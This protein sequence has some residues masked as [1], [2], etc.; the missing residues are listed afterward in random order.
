[1]KNMKRLLALL[2]A[3]TTTFSFAACGKTATEGGKSNDKNGAAA[4]TIVADASGFESK[5]SPFFSQCVDR[6]DDLISYPF[7]FY[8]IQFFINRDQRISHQTALH[9]QP[10]VQH[11]EK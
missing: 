7:D 5:F 8:K 1:M 9:R 6:F 10:P 3:A 2:L 11:V 4:D